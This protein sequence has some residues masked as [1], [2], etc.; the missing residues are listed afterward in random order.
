MVGDTDIEACRNDSITRLKARV[1]AADDGSREVDAADTG[2]PADD[3]AG[4]GGSQCILVIHAGVGDL[5]GHLAR[6]QLRLTPW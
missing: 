6:V 1:A 5:D 3:S 4:T 2:V